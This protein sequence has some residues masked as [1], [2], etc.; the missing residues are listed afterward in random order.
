MAITFVASTRTPSP[1]PAAA[2]NT[3]TCAINKPTGVTTGDVMVAFIEAG[4]VTITAVP[5]GWTQVDSLLVTSSNMLSAV[6][7]KVATASE[8]ASYTWT[9][10]SGNTTPLCGGIV[11]YRGVDTANPVN[12]Q[13]NGGDD[14]TTPPDPDTTPAVTTTA[15]CRILYF[16]ACKTSTVASEGTFTASQTRRQRFSNRGAS[17]QYY[18]EIWDNN[19]DVAA[20]SQSGLSM[21]GSLTNTGSIVRT[22]ALKA[23]PDPSSGT[24][25][26]TLPSVTSSFAGSVTIP[27]GSISASLPPAVADMI[28]VAAPP[29]GTMDTSLAPVTSSLSGNATGG[30]LA[31]GL[32]PLVADVAGAV[33]PIGP[34]GMTLPSLSTAWVGETQPFGEHVIHVE[35]ESRCFRVVDE[36][37]GLKDVSRKNLPPAPSEGP[38]AAQLPLVDSAID[39]TAL[40]PASGTL[41]A[42]APS[43]TS[44]VSGFIDLPVDGSM[45][46]TLPSLTMT[47]TGQAQPKIEAYLSYTQQSRGKTSYGNNSQ[48]IDAVLPSWWR[49]ASDGSVVLQ[50]PPTTVED[51]A[52]IS[53]VNGNGDEAWGVVANYY[54]SGNWDW[55]DVHTILNNTTLRS[56][57]ITNLVNLAVSKGY[58][59]IDVDFEQGTDANDRQPFTDFC[60]A[61]ATALHNAG[62][63]LCVTVQPKLSEPG[64]QVRHQIQDWAALGAVADQFQIMLYDY[65]PAAG[66]YSQSPFTWWQD[67]GRFAPTLVDRN[68]ILLGGPTYGY[69]WSGSTLVEDLEW[70]DCDSLRI[71]QG[72]TWLYDATEKSPYFTYTSGATTHTVYAEDATSLATRARFVRQKGFRGM[73]VWRL[74]G[75]APSV[76]QSMQSAMEYGT[77]I[78]YRNAAAT[79]TPGA[80][81]VSTFNVNKPSGTVNGDLMIAFITV[82]EI[83][84]NI[85][86]TPP[87]GWTQLLGEWQSSAG[88]ITSQVWYKFAGGSEPS[89]YAWTFDTAQEAG[90]IIA[91]YSGVNTTTPFIDSQLTAAG[92]TD[93]QATTA[94]TSTASN[95]VGVFFRSIKDNAASQS[96]TALNFFER[97]DASDGDATAVYWMYLTMSDSNGSLGPPGTY[98]EKFDFSGS[99][100][101]SNLAAVVLNPA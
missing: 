44:S 60:T 93:P 81:T 25:G 6:Y 85:T 1:F 52:F 62:K 71:A 97:V 69:H 80:T 54:G 79:I 38:V 66:P 34:I 67:I 96:S 83:S 61:L 33:A 94:V 77:T 51:T 89:T 46:A 53:T 17:T 41:D 58:I 68:K 39:A 50:Q 40:T 47:G 9:D 3:S 28:G 2:N 98:S 10:G 16:R 48:Y 72:A 88:S 55:T 74:A 23:L 99:P 7:Y 90:A 4:N 12:V 45:S 70:A 43:V 42:T 78:M 20:G 37:P 64:P 56:T 84:T 73:F 5:S 35:A 86:M 18:A 87:A 92:A 65:D 14:G 24:L 29:S 100:Q 95:Q 21:D 57:F 36:D 59:G 11:A 76:Y 8:P 82:R 49:P 31:A 75:E 91:S 27:S 19:A 63:L 22:L 32:S 13:A 26:A 30:P 101:G 15:T